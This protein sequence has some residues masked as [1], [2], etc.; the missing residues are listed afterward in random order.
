MVINMW[1]IFREK[2]LGSNVN[3]VDLII[4]DFITNVFKPVQSFSFPKTNGRSFRFDWL[5][6]FP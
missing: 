5:Q 6:S 4:K 3:S 1:V 2:V